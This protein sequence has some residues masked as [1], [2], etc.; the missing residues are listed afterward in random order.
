MTRYTNL[1]F[2]REVHQRRFGI[3]TRWVGFAWGSNDCSRCNTL[4]VAPFC[5]DIAEQ[6]L[7][8]IR[9]LGRDPGIKISFLEMGTASTR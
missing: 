6:L 9:A 5:T 3:V 4:G 7:Q 8:G 1:Y 2:V